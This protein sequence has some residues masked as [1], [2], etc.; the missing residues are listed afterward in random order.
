MRN[1]SDCRFLLSPLNTRY[2][3]S[4]T[5]SSWILAVWPNGTAQQKED[6]W[7]IQGMRLA[8]KEPRNQ[9]HKTGDGSPLL[10]FL[11]IVYS[12]LG[13]QVLEGRRIR[14]VNH[15]SIQDQSMVSSPPI[16]VHKEFWSSTRWVEVCMPQY[17]SSWH[18][19]LGVRGHGARLIQS[20]A[21]YFGISWEYYQIT[22]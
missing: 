10:F 3:F 14:R 17:G 22:A 6:L 11:K 18:T 21:E 15:R 8:L 12:V 20:Q 16:S 13:C 9:D 2:F 4:Q 7:L 1:Q 5:R 19:S